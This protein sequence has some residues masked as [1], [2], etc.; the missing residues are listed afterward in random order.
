M[1]RWSDRVVKEIQRTDWHLQ[2]GLVRKNVSMI[3]TPKV[4]V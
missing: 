3:V 4:Q 2:T 1:Y